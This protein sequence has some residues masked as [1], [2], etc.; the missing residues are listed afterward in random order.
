[1]WEEAKHPLSENSAQGKDSK[2]RRAVSF[3]KHFGHG[4]CSTRRRA[5]SCAT[6]V[7]EA[8]G[9]IL[10]LGI[11]FFLDLRKRRHREQNLPV[12][13][14]GEEVSELA[15]IP[16]N[17][18]DYTVGRSLY[19]LDDEELRKML[20]GS[21]ESG[22]I[23]QGGSTLIQVADAE[24]TESNPFSEL[25]T[26]DPLWSTPELPS[27]P[28]FRSPL[29]EL[30]APTNF[31]SIGLYGR[32][33][34]W[35]ENR[36]DQS[37]NFT[38][39]PPSSKA[40][41]PTS[42][43]VPPLDKILNPPKVDRLIG[44]DETSKLSPSENSAVI[45]QNP[46]FRPTGELTEKR[47]NSEALD[48]RS[49][50]T[51]LCMKRAEDG[52]PGLCNPKS[53][54]RGSALEPIAL[55]AIYR[56]QRISEN[57]GLSSTE[58]QV[59]EICALVYIVNA[60]WNNRMI[61][62]PNLLMRCATLPLPAL[63]LKGVNALRQSFRGMFL[64]TFEDTFALAH[65]ACAIA[66]TLHKDNDTYRWEDLFV[67]MR[68]LHHAIADKS[69]KQLFL[70][71]MECLTWN[72]ETPRSLAR[73]RDLVNRISYS[74]SRRCELCRYY[75]DEALTRRDSPI[76]EPSVG[77]P[78][79]RLNSSHREEVMTMLRNGIIMRDCSSFL[80]GMLTRPHS[81]S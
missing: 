29:F 1:M 79:Q 73:Q 61:D 60:E 40:V 39:A 32:K 23:L 9:L 24:I 76:L 4:D 63:I 45:F 3:F 31:Q 35:V 69:D 21:G 57:S 48:G 15:T 44:L 55:S 30:P 59:E 11:P 72:S 14:D 10:T 47:M 43:A 13:L 53:L 65:V 12:E 80:D 75:R 68:Q 58:S 37:D 74:R 22:F 7:A 20:C 26:L 56:D 8:S 16:N 66:Y 34:D 78:H 42:V 77:R 6:S 49:T 5:R 36:G 18:R 81:P 50:D 28:P 52:I 64:E 17:N 70:E 51:Q 71:A 19:E 67:D 33:S 38:T 54:L 2:F 41:S 25:A 46:I 62:L 27:L